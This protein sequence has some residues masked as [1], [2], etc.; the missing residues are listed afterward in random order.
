MIVGFAGYVS[1]I[2]SQHVCAKKGKKGKKKKTL[3][4]NWVEGFSD[5]IIALS[6]HVKNLETQKQEFL[7]LLNI[8]SP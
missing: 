3:I 1:L 8:F 4:T 7:L 6:M 2:F 5:I